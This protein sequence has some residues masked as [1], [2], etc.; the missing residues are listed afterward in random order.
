MTKVYTTSNC[1]RCKKLKKY[2]SE[3]EIKFEEENMTKPEARTELA[4]KDIFPKS[5]PVLKTKKDNYYK[6]NTLFD[7]N[8]IRKQKLNRIIQEE[9]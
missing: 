1:P 9:T 7:Q 6:M 4:M 8:T 3:K 5:A 2:L